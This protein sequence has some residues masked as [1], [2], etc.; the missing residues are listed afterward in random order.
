MLETLKEKS[1][2]NGVLEEP[3]KITVYYSEFN[4]E[5]NLIPT[6]INNKQVLVHFKP[7]K[8]Y[9]EKLSYYPEMGTEEPEISAEDL[10]SQINILNK[11][12]SLETLDL[13]FHEIHDGDDAITNLKDEYQTIYASM[14]EL[15]N[16]YGYDLIDEYILEKTSK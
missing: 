3:H 9:V 12:V 10:Q 13:L 2:F 1:W 15:Y 8:P 6:K 5:L 7:K 4:P 14:E 11:L 16:I